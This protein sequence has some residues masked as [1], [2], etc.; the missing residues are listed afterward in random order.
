VAKEARELPLVVAAAGV[1][2]QEHL[3]QARTDN[4]ATAVQAF[5][6]PAESQRLHTWRT[7]VTHMTLVTL[8]KMVAA[9]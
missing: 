1:R 5:S 6:A 2:A 3:E 9:E 7:Q 4:Q 8:R